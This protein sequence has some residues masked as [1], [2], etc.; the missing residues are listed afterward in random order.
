MANNLKPYRCTHC[1]GH[2]NFLPEKQESVDGIVQY[3][4]LQ[5][6]EL[7]GSTN[8]LQRLAVTHLVIPVD[9]GQGH[10]YSEF[11][12]K[13]FKFICPTASK[14]YEK[15]GRPPVSYSDSVAVVTCPECLKLAAELL[16][17][18]ETLE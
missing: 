11:R 6:C 9:K 2:T 8:S 12:Q 18:V 14:I 5:P 7:C 15:E 13:D 1:R 16:E 17:P 10:Y 3:V 4:P